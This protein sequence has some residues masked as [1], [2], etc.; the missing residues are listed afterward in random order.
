MMGLIR[1]KRT[2]R[3]GCASSLRRRGQLA[4]LVVFFEI[5]LRNYDL[6]KAASERSRDIVNGSSS[7]CWNIV[8]R[9]RVAEF[10]KS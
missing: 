7:L 3:L 5:L 4:F 6:D 10:D 2:V 1:I 9:R 8:R